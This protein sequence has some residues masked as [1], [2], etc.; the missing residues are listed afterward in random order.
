VIVSPEL[1]A[2]VRVSSSSHRVSCTCHF[3]A[4]ASFLS[5]CRFAFWSCFSSCFRLC[6]S[7]YVSSLRRLPSSSSLASSSASTRAQRSASETSRSTLRRRSSFVSWVWYIPYPG[8]VCGAECSWGVVELGCP[9]LNCD[10]APNVGPEDNSETHREPFHVVPGGPFVFGSP[11]WLF[12]PRT[13]RSNRFTTQWNGRPSPRACAHVKHKPLT[14]PKSASRAKNAY[15]PNPNTS[16]V[17]A[18]SR[19]TQT[20]QK[21]TAAHKPKMRVVR[22]DTVESRRIARRGRDRQ[23]ERWK[24]AGRGQLFGTEIIVSLSVKKSPRVELWSFRL[25]PSLHVRV[26]PASPARRDARCSPGAHD[27]GRWCSW[28]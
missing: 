14:E 21:E 1:V 16:P 6:A 24:S 13:L 12:P 4:L 23:C 27:A 10:D 7:P 2:R 8:V 28:A 17:G 19:T 5:S 22:R 25:R 9:L 11:F 18:A 26:T 15:V 3:R 20:K